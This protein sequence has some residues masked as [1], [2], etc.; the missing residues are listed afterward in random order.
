MPAATRQTPAP[1]H[2]AREEDASNPRDARPHRPPRDHRP[3]QPRP[4]EPR[5]GRRSRR[6]GSCRRT[7]TS[8]RDV[9]A[10]IRAG[11]ILVHHP[12]ESFAASVERFIAQAADDPEV[13]TIKKTLYRTSRRLADR[14]RPDPRRGARQAGRRARRDQGPLRRGGEHRLGPQAGAG[15]RPRRL[16][17]RRAQD[18]LARSRSS[19]GARAA[20]PALRPHRDRQLQPADR[21]PVHGPRPAVVPP[22]ARRGRDGPVQRP[23]RAVAPAIVPAPARR[24]AQPAVGGSSSWSSAR[25]GTPRRARRRGSC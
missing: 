15:R 18:A 2:R 13:L 23:D 22:G 9:F 16:R 3:G 19:S 10:A 17:P 14:P 6:P 4:Q 12:Y 7:R 21:P 24:A 11:D 8:R 1:R 20:A 5:R 25:S